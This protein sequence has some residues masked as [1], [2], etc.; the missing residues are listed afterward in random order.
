MMNK[1]VFITSTDI[2]GKIIT[3]QNLLLEFWTEIKTIWL[4]R[5]SIIPS[6]VAFTFHSLRER[7]SQGFPFRS[8]H[9]NIPSP[10]S[11]FSH[12]FSRAVLPIS[13]RY[14]RFPTNG[15]CLLND[16]GMSIFIHRICR[17]LEP[18]FTS[19]LRSN[20]FFSFGRAVARVNLSIF[21]TAFIVT[22]FT[23]ATLIEVSTIKAESFK[24]LRF[25]FTLN[26]AIFAIKFL[27]DNYSKGL[28]ALRANLSNFATSPM[29]IKTSSPSF[30]PP[31]ITFPTAKMMATLRLPKR[32]LKLFTASIANNPYHTSNY[33]ISC[34]VS[35]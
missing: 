27:R 4:A 2:A 31:L 19:I 8:S 7:F 24:A 26:R 33:I 34:E 9:K 25:R 28:I 3:L 16:T 15:T 6:R 17:T 13:R 35:Q 29:R 20:P 32:S 30:T 23:Q 14:E 5:S 21:K 1:K 18:L 10:L 12:T 22:K 11:I